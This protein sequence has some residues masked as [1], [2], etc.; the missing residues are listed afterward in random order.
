MSKCAL[1]KRDNRQAGARHT[2]VP[3]TTT[4]Q[5][6]NSSRHGCPTAI[7]K[8]SHFQLIIEESLDTRGIEYFSLFV[9]PPQPARIIDQASISLPLPPD[10]CEAWFKGRTG[11]L[12]DIGAQ[13]AKHR[14][15]R[16]DF[17]VVPGDAECL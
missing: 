12:A 3:V 14:L 11:P 15:R 17:F 5:K 13:S 10:E 6:R 4:I 2:H 16:V 7:C 9:N 8:P 1:R